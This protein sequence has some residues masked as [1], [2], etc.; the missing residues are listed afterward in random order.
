MTMRP[1][2]AAP[3]PMVPA[4]MAQIAELEDALFDRPLTQSNLDIL[5]GGTAFVGWVI[6]EAPGPDEGAG[7]RAFGDALL[8]R[9]YVL[10]H[11]HADQAEIL[12]IGTAP[13]HQR[14]RIATCLIDR[15]IADLGARK[16]PHL[17]LEVAVDNGPAL[18]LYETMGFTQIG[19]RNAYY[20]RDYG[21]CDALVLRR[22]L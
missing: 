17:F 14:Q 21:R 4:H 20:K 10:L 16:V 7:D 18:S 2:L 8:V 13:T 22:D 15:V 12:S 5:A 6:G 3:V 1:H 19:R 9:G 11:V